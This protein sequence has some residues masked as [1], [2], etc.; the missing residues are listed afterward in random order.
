MT[1]SRCCSNA[2]D[3]GLPSMR[4]DTSKLFVRVLCLVMLIAVFPVGDGWSATVEVYYGPDDAPLDR[5]T[6]LYRRATRYLYV[7][8]Y[9]LT[10][11]RAVEAMVAAKKRGV[12][13]R[14]ITDRQRTEDLKQRTALTTLQLAGIPILVNEHDGLM[15]LKQVVID[16]EVNTTGSMNHTTS[17]NSYNDER[18]DVITDHVITVRAREKF[19]AM[20]NDHTRFKEWK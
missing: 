16:D 15:H 20:W 1:I 4:I 7:A 10:S 6:V 14:M 13:V 2:N 18:L 5:L 11:P 17:G 19:L 8:V 9:G 3:S 12:D